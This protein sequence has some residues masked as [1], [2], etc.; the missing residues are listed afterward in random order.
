[1]ITTKKDWE[2]LLAK[3]R[4]GNPEAQWEVG[5]YYEDGLVNSDEEIIV[6]P[7]QKKAV[8]WHILSAKQGEESSQLALGNLLSSGKERDVRTAINWTIKALNQ[9]S[10]SAAHNLGAIYRDLGKL[11]LAFK[12]YNKAIN[13]GDL[14]SLF[15][16]GLCYLFGIGTEQNPEKAYK[17]FAK[18]IASDKK[19]ICKRTGEDAHYWLAILHLLNIGGADKSVSKAK[20]CLEVANKDF[21][22][23]Q[24]NELL[25]IIGKREL[26]ISCKDIEK[27]YFIKPQ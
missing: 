1:M 25:N 3:A 16:V 4:Q 21:D 6:K 22:H 14:D 27:K 2:N 8:E 26:E 18:I 24:A 11:S 5:S 10:A 19:H 9:G 13:M 12:W 20:K 23:E 17:S 15:Q 7:N